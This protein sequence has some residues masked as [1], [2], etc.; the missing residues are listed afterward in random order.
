MK[1]IP[2]SPCKTDR[3][4]PL[5]VMLAQAGTRRSNWRALRI[6]NASSNFGLSDVERLGLISPAGLWLDDHP[7][8]DLFATLPHELPELRST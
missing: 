5:A 4:N 2:P 1:R 8:P 7:I 3:D 6:M